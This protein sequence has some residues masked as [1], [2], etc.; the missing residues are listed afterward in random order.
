MPPPCTRLPV[1]RLDQRRP[2]R[3]E[4]RIRVRLPEGR[5]GLHRKAF[6]KKCQ[7]GGWRRLRQQ[8]PTDPVGSSH[9]EQMPGRQG[10]PARSGPAGHAAH[11][12]QGRF[13]AVLHRR[14]SYIPFP[15]A[16]L[17]SSHTNPTIANTAPAPEPL[18]MTTPSRACTAQRNA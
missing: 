9:H 4:I 18:P 5:F 10:L 7:Q 8:T 13:Q 1:F 12:R 6:A 11:S 14:V 15:S 3:V 17:L 2:Q 16:P